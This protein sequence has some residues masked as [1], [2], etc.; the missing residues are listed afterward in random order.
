MTGTPY[1]W[2][3]DAKRYRGAGGRFVSRR[4]VRA[5]LDVTLENS[6]KRMNALADQL[7]KGEI[8]LDTWLRE[9]RGTVKAVHLYSTAAAKGGWDQLT[10]KD[11]GRVGRILRDQYTYLDRFAA[12]IEAGLPLDGRF[13]TRVRMYMQSGRRTYYDAADRLVDEIGGFD[14][15][16]SVLHPA[17]HCDECVAQAALGWQPRGAMI[18]IG[19]RICKSNCRCTKEYLNS[20]TGQVW[21]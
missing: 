7:R 14:R 17:D 15:E 13:T 18:P 1:A 9:M 4:A 16:R 20:S 5:A 3:A 19:E 8:N 12:D 6:G 10:K 11:F 2:D 21:S